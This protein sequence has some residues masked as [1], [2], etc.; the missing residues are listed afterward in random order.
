M[1]MKNESITARD[2]DFAQW[3]TDV[4]KKAE[5][6]DYSSV[7]G[8]I[9]YL[10]YGYA[11][12]EEIQA[13]MN[14]RFKEN[15]ASN[16]YLP[17]VIPSSLFNK[18][19]EHVEGF[20]PECLVATIGGGEKLA[21]PLIIRPT[22]EILFSDMYKRLV[23]SYRDLPKIYN[24][25]CSVV[26][27]EKTTRPFL[28]GAEF[29]WQEGHC[30]FETHEQA[31]QN[32]KTFLDI[33]DDCGRDLLAIPFVKGRKTEHEKFAGALATYSIE[34]LMHDGKA[35]Q[36]GT[37]HD[38]GQGFAEA[39]GIAYQGRKNALEVPWQTSWGAST[40]LIGAII[41]VH[42]DD[43]GL[44][45]PPYVAPIQVVI[46]PIRQS[47]PGVLDACRKIEATLKAEGLRVKLDDDDSKTPGWKFSEYEM[48]GVPLRIEVG[49]RDLAAGN[50]VLV[51]R[52]NGE[53]TIAKIEEIEKEIPDVMK[54]IHALMYQKALD[55]LNS[56]ITDVD[57]LEELNAVLNK[58]GYARMAFC[59]DEACELK[60]KELTNGG[61]TRCIYKESVPE[62]T[63]CPVCGKPAKMIVYFARAY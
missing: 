51:K 14:R 8:F 61:T 58:G 63:L 17:M 54:Q 4:C 30:L 18:E 33:Y 25:W 21:D 41:M 53:K 37:S 13:Y 9:D 2:V 29:L 59:G 34:A 50:A 26:R 27:W 3:Y 31:Q 52:V 20:A 49:P 38:L 15:G 48:K 16:V 10:P 6:M 47:E 57:S 23:T 19:K 39:F 22:S 46:V 36:A 24:Q 60:I 1:A 55:H 35:L 11:I 28:R 12:W 62:G 44:V 56:S 43:N 5:L 32:V 45:L 7:K 40:R 42:G